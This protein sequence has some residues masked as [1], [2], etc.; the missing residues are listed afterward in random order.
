MDIW[1]APTNE[2]KVLFYETLLCMN[3]TESEIAYVRNEDFTDYFMITIG[4]RPHVIDVLTT[5]H[6]KLLFDEAEKNIII[7][8]AG[9]GIEL[10]M[11]PY[12]FLKDETP[13]VKAKRSF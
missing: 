2:N 3:Y 8:Q 1:I 5:V 4:A 10:K 13:F 11:V 12:H 6:Y 9:E 7:H